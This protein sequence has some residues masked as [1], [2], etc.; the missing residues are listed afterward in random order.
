[1]LIVGGYLLGSVPF[2]YLVT[3]LSR[4]T[5][6]RAIGSGNP[7]GANVL[8]H[9]GV[10]PGVVAGALDIGK[11]AL[12]VYIGILL[13]ASPPVLGLVA[14]GV[15]VGHCF[16]FFL[17]FM[18]GQGLSTAFGTLAPLLPF[19]IGVSVLVGCLT[20]FVWRPYRTRGWFGSSLHVGALAGFV[21]MLILA[22]LQQDRAAFKALPVVLGAI[23]LL[24]QVIGIKD[25][26][27]ATEAN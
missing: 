2:A 1:M 11:G 18:G 20:G 27:H 6:I 12:A 7:G 17:R 19:E 10:F 13:D 9:V 21:L 3:Q 23:V 15:T 24:R 22:V 16:S 8:T 25:L 4:G 14:L 5:D 26:R